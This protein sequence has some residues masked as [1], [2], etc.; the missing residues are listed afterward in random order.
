MRARRGGN[1]NVTAKHA[2]VSAARRFAPGMRRFGSRAPMTQQNFGDTNFNFGNPSQSAMQGSGDPY[3][4]PYASAT[5]D[6]G[7][8]YNAM[9]GGG[10]GYGDPYGG[11]YGGGQYGGAVPDGDYSQ[12]GEVPLSP[13]KKQGRWIRKNNRIIL[14]G[15]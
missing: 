3:G 13:S 9:Q 6:G 12:M 15:V 14:L 8:P 5:P 7:D 11:Q 1:P 4:D 10:D 2:I